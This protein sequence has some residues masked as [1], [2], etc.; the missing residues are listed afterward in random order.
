MRHCSLRSC[1]TLRSRTSGGST[2]TRAPAHPPYRRCGCGTSPAAGRTPPNPGPTRQGTSCR[3]PLGNRNV[4]PRLGHVPANPPQGGGGYVHFDGRRALLPRLCSGS[5]L[6]TCTHSFDD[7][8]ALCSPSV[9]HCSSPSSYRRSATT[10]P[11][12]SLQTHRPVATPSF[13]KQISCA[14]S[15]AHRLPWPLRTL[16]PSSGISRNRSRGRPSREVPHSHLD[17]RMPV[18]NKA[19]RTHACR[20]H[21]RNDRSHVHGLLGCRIAS[22]QAGIIK[23]FRHVVHPG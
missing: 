11:P 14:L 15:A 12:R 20:P 8:K 19:L 22:N 16:S 10:A 17:A 3:F 13:Q 1:F 2:H 9:S 21:R 23:G 6:P 7:G 5:K 4:D 18:C